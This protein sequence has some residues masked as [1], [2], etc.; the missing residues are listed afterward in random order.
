M[1][2]QIVYLQAGRIL[3]NASH[4]ELMARPDGV[5]RSLVESERSGLVEMRA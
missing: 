3:E 2:D 4:D 5:Y 1:G